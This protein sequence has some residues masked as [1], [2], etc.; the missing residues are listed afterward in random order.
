MSSVWP[1][2]AII[3]KDCDSVEV[4]WTRR[5]DASSGGAE[6]FEVGIRIASL[7]VP[8]LSRATTQANITRKRVSLTG[9]ADAHMTA[10]N[11][12]VSAIQDNGSCEFELQSPCPTDLNQDGATTTD[13][14]EFLISFECTE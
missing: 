3:W 9:V 2:A 8:S 13:L 5:F 14:L 1:T 7:D 4:G 11:Y 12:D 6:S 10:Q